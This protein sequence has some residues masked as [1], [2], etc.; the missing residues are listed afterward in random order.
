MDLGQDLDN[1][2]NLTPEEHEAQ[3]KPTDARLYWKKWNKFQAV[4]HLF[5]DEVAEINKN[6]RNKTNKK[7]LGKH[8]TAINTWFKAL[9]ESKLKEAK[10]AAAKWNSEGTSYKEKMRV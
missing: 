7:D 6:C 5:A 3:A 1:N 10:N 4:Q 8:T 2:G 9:S